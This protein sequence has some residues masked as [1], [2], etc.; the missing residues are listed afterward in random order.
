MKPDPMGCF[1]TAD[2]MSA[3]FDS[4]TIQY[5][6]GGLGANSCQYANFLV[7]P[8]ESELY[9]PYL[10]NGLTTEELEVCAAELMQRITDDFGGCL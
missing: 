4:G 8:T 7:E 9:S 6:V 1:V 5:E 3:T 10:D 2:F